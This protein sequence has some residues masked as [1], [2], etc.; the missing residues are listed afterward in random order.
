MEHH[1]PFI[2][3]E[4]L[5]QRG[6]RRAPTDERRGAVEDED[7]ELSRSY[8]PSRERALPPAARESFQTRTRTPACLLTE[9]W[10]TLRETQ[11]PVFGWFRE[12]MTG[13]ADTFF[14]ITGRAVEMT[15]TELQELRTPGP[16]PLQLAQAPHSGLQRMARL[17]LADPTFFVNNDPPPSRR[18]ILKHE[19]MSI[20]LP[21]NPSSLSYGFQCL[22]CQL[23]R[24]VRRDNLDAPES[25]HKTYRFHCRDVSVDC[26]EPTRARWSFSPTRGIPGIETAPVYEPSETPSRRRTEAPEMGTSQTSEPANPLIRPRSRTPPPTEN[27]PSITPQTESDPDK[28]RKSMKLWAGAV[29]YDGSPSL[30]KLK[31][32][33]VSLNEAFQAIGV[34]PGRMQVMQGV[35][36]LKGKAEE[37]WQEIVGQPQGQNLRTF[38]ALIDALTNTFIPQSVYDKAMIDWRDLKQTGTAEEYSRRVDQLAMILPLGEVS[39]YRHSLLGMRPELKAEIQFRM[40]EQNRDSCPRK[41]LW[42]LMAIAEV[43]FP[44]RPFRP[45]FGKPKPKGATTKAAAADASALVVCW[46]CDTTGHRANTCEKRHPSGC[47]RCGSKA[48][49]LM[50]CPQRP[51]AKKGGQGPKTGQGQRPGQGTSSMSGKKKKGRESA[52]ASTK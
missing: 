28:W 29:T 20:I 33:G 36:Y 13:C 47:A 39:E 9:A 7:R 17:A 23:F 41:E 35:H 45:F 26:H 6:S 8:S 42:E 40:K 27:R 37:W 15:K 2:K 1:L 48:H 14:A 12:D 21:G 30:V 3:E 46:I 22:E 16:S 49:N 50:T 18:P 52:S 11:E 43:R 38:D 32:W 51:N 24:V 10:V 44:H 19:W 5:S 25:L 34:P 4:P 31:G